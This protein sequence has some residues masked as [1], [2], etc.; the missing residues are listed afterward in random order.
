[1]YKLYVRPH[2][3]YGDIIYHTDAELSL[4]F[5]KKLEATQ[6]SAAFAVSGA[7]SKCKLYEELRGKLQSKENSRF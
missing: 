5:T 3:D 6:Y 1:M 2:L 7:T 4:D